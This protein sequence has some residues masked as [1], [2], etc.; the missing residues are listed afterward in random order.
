MRHWLG[1]VAW[2]SG[3]TVTEGFGGSS[4]SAQLSGSTIRLIASYLRSPLE[5]LNPKEVLEK[6]FDRAFL[7]SLKGNETAADLEL[8]KKTGN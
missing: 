4:H 1:S 6:G 7:K 5:T 2:G 3:P 8:P